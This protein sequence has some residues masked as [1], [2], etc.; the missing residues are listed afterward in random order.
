MQEI[1]ER[2]TQINVRP[3][4]AFLFAAFNYLI[5]PDAAYLPA[6][7]AVWIAVLLDIFTRLFANSRKAGG[8]IKAIRQRAISSD[9]LWSKTAVKVVAYLSV[10]ILAGLSMRVL[11]LEQVSIAVATIIYSFLFIREATSV[12]ENLVEAGAED[13]QPLLFWLKKKEKDLTEDQLRIAPINH[14]DEEPETYNKPTI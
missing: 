10:Q 6:I 2:L 1:I 9:T 14:E 4:W 8:F 5:C 12:I 13:L 3:I 7:C 11:P